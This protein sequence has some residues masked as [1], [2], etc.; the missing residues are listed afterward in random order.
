MATKPRKRSKSGF[1]HVFQRGVSLFDIFEDDE[2]REFYLQRLVRYASEIGV[3]IHAWCLLSNHTHLLLRADRES[4]SSL[5]R[6]LGSVYARFFN[7]RHG[8]TGPLFE[9][10]F[11]SVCVETDAQ[12]MSV[13]RYIHRNPLHHEERTLIGDYQWSSFGEYAASSPKTCEIGFALYLFGGVDEL[14]RF[15]LQKHD[16]DR[17]RH[18]DI[19]TI[20]PMR[21]EEARMRANQALLDAGFEI[22]VSRIGSLP[23]K[24]RDAAIACVKR[25]VGCSLRQIQRLTAVAYSAIRDAVK[26]AFGD[27]FKGGSDESFD[28]MAYELADPLAHRLFKGRSATPLPRLIT[29]KAPID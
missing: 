22:Q 11:G 20:G 28:S 19:G 5:M 24:L 13:I 26:L 10:R 25:A 2:D 4:L 16:S 1:Y 3:E 15:H 14:V 6:K 27:A 12:F 23:R 9:R 18:L 17:E 7:A 29:R 21:D 8:R